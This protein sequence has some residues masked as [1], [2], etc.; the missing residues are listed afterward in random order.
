MLSSSTQQMS[1]AGFRSRFHRR[2]LEHQRPLS[3]VTMA[4]TVVAYLAFVVARSLEAGPA[5]P[6]QYRLAC[7]L[8]LALLVVAIPGTKSTW[9]FGGIGIAYAL[10][11]QAGIALNIVGLEQPLLWALPA[12]VVIP[13]CAAPL[14][15][16][17]VHFLAGTLLFYAT[18]LPLLLDSPQHRAKSTSCAGCGWRS[19]CRPLRCF[20]SPF[21]GSGA[22][23]SCLKT[24][25][26]DLRRP[27]R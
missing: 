18:G 24:G 3:T 7:A 9:V 20:T 10:V 12:L 11:M 6:I 15:L 8:C 4:F 1:D 13:I 2:S 17:P 5:V 16:T 26:R 23:I 14:W 25:W 19:A 22:I 27:T 21:T